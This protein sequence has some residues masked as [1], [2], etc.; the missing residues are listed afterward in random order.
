MS[1][2]DPEKPLDQLPNK[3]SNIYVAEAKELW[4]ELKNNKLEVELAPADPQK[5][6]N[7]KIRV[8]VNSNP[9]WYSELY[10]E[11]DYLER[12]NSLKSLNRLMTRDDPPFREDNTN[13]PIPYHFCYVSKYREFIHN[14]LKEGW[15]PEG[16][17]TDCVSP[18]EEVRNFFD[19]Q[20]KNL[21]FELLPYD[22][23]NNFYSDDYEKFNRENQRKYISLN[24]SHLIFNGKLIRPQDPDDGIPREEIEELEKQRIK[25]GKID[26][27]NEPLY[28]K[29]I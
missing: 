28:K 8:V 16:N 17:K 22:S 18:N 20:I 29:N 2:F 19:P 10:D 12:R 13:S 9:Q 1:E 21:N 11:Y 25:K 23:F 15:G 27:E 24:E 14:R 4:E 7:H 6:S 26:L 5:F 3:I